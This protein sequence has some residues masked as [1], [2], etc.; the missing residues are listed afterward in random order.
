[1]PLVLLRDGYPAPRATADLHGDTPKLQIPPHAIL[2]RNLFTG[3]HAAM[4]NPKLEREDCSTSHQKN[5]INKRPPYFNHGFPL[6]P[7]SFGTHGT[8]NAA[9]G[10]GNK[11][12]CDH[13]NAFI[14][15][16]P[17]A[18]LI[19][20]SAKSFSWLKAPQ[21]PLPASL[22]FPAEALALSLRTATPAK[23][24]FATPMASLHFSS[25][26]RATGIYHK[27]FKRDLKVV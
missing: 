27:N 23:T 17:L 13:T 9:L 12:D 15:K 4:I 16:T 20:F 14:Y 8:R 26:L 7:S 18:P 25:T 3:G 5:A 10:S 19:L 2:Q 11:A 24:A 1:M 6:Q 22:L 21:R